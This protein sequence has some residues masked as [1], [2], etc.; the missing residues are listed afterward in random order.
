VGTLFSYNL[1]RFCSDRWVDDEYFP[2][3]LERTGLYKRDVVVYRTVIKKSLL[4]SCYDL[5]V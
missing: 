2:I 3:K 4:S 5:S 1:L